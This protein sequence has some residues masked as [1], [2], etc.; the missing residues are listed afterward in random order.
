[1]LRVGVKV[2]TEEGTDVGEFRNTVRR[3]VE[4]MPIGPVTG[5]RV[6]GR[7]IGRVAREEVAM[8]VASRG[9]VEGGI[10]VRI[11]KV[12]LN[13]VPARAEGAGR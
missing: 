5:V 11:F 6:A 13:K 10:A 12:S 4:A 3:G 8:I 7:C 9:R 1:M 2:G